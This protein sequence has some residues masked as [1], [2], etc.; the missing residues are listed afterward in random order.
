MNL[1]DGGQ[2]VI[3]TSLPFNELNKLLCQ[4]FNAY[5]GVKSITLN[6]GVYTIDYSNTYHVRQIYCKISSNNDNNQ[7]KHKYL[8]TFFY[9]SKDT[10]IWNV[11]EYI[12]C[13]IPIVIIGALFFSFLGGCIL[14]CSYC[15]IMYLIS[16]WG[17]I[18]ANLCNQFIRD[19]DNKIKLMS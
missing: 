6:N 16:S 18:P 17:K 15:L 10:A 12:V 4:C 3:E 8:L 9:G 2:L 14:G 5:L 19:I 1:S 11:L 13:F 7:Q